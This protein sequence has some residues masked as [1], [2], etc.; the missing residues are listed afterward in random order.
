MIVATVIAS[1]GSAIRIAPIAGSLP[2]DEPIRIYLHLFRSCLDAAPL[3]GDGWRL[4]IPAEDDPVRE[5][6]NWWLAHGDPNA[7]VAGSPAIV[8]PRHLAE[9]V[10]SPPAGFTAGILE[11]GIT[12]AD[13]AEYV[14]SPALPASDPALLHLRGNESARASV[15]L[16]TRR[17]TPPPKVDV[18]P[19]V[20]SVRTWATSAA[21]FAEGASY[22]VQWSVITGAARYEVWRALDDGITG[23]RTA[24]DDSSRRSLAAA[25]PEAFELRSKSGVRELLSRSSAGTRAHARLLSRACRGLERCRG[26]VLVGDRTRIR[27]RR[28]TSSGAEHAARRCRRGRR[29]RDPRRM[30]L[31]PAS[32]SAWGSSSSSG[33]RMAMSGS[34]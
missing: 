23:A 1:E 6:W 7:V 24:T 30:E 22:D 11:L 15:V 8:F 21:T 10:A 27:A 3:G 9:V 26:L 20:P 14:A 32:A 28:A 31:N 34:R 25:Q 33:P 13:A 29:P 4:A 17:P 18:G 19:W 2:V 16:S 12:A 5:V